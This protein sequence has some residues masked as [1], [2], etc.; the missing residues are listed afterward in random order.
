M[1]AS[2]RLA[3]PGPSGRDRTTDQLIE[4]AELG[5][6]YAE[7]YLAQG[8]TVSVCPALAVH[9]DGGTT[10]CAVL[11][12][13]SNKKREMMRALGEQCRR[14]CMEVRAICL[15]SEA[16]MSCV[17]AGQPIKMMPSQDP[18]RVEIVQVSARTSDGG[19]RVIWHRRVRRS[20]DDRLEW[21]G[22]WNQW[23]DGRAG[24]ALL[25]EFYVGYFGPP[26]NIN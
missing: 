12:D 10:I 26:T 16:W 7:H 21:D 11:G 23:Q 6:R 3:L 9:H 24:T 20:A 2:N 17:P 4:A 14:M 13:F 22:D 25:D 18:D 1:K 8:G 15:T 5:K 19:A